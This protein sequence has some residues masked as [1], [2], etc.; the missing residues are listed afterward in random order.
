MATWE[1]VDIDPTDLD[2]KGE[3]DYEWG[4]DLMNDLERRFN[5]LRQFNKTLN[6]SRDEDLINMTTITRDA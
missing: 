4:D 5:E 3:E 6:E 1:P 2:D